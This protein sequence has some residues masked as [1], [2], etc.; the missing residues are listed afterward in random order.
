MLKHNRTMELYHFCNACSL[1][2]INIVLTFV[3]FRWMTNRCATNQVTTTI[4]TKKMELAS[5][6]I[7]DDFVCMY[8]SK[9]HTHMLIWV[10]YFLE[11]KMHNAHHACI[12]RTH[13][14]SSARMYIFCALRCPSLLFLPQCLF[15]LFR[16]LFVHVGCVFHA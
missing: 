15:F 8:E 5:S 9:W 1:V 12:P 4:T 11:Y 13:E 2:V 10:E 7:N 14:R 3:N 6:I 16:Y